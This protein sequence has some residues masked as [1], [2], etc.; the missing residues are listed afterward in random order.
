MVVSLS[1]RSHQKER[2]PQRTTASPSEA[3]TFAA[4]SCRITSTLTSCSSMMRQSKSPGKS[5]TEEGEEEGGCGGAGAVYAAVAGGA[6]AGADSRCRGWFDK[7]REAVA[8]TYCSQKYVYEFVFRLRVSSSSQW[9]QRGRIETDCS[10]S[11]AGRGDVSVLGDSRCA[12]VQFPLFLSLCVG[13]P[14]CI[15]FCFAKWCPSGLNS[16]S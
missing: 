15:F 13:A 6:G 12:L 7:R 4:T 10:V 11:R 16:H 5:K 2:T 8:S 9:L 14:R 3:T 1:G